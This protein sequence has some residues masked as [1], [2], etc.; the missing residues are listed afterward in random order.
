[1]TIL[2]VGRDP[3]RTESKIYQEFEEYLEESITVLGLVVVPG[4][5][6]TAICFPRHPVENKCP[7]ITLLT[8]D[9]Q[10]KLSND[11]LQE[12]CANPRGAFHEA[13]T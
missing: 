11:V 2:F 9:W 10:A 13:Y 3:E 1:M 8:G 4:K 12:T 5:I 7:H 6:I